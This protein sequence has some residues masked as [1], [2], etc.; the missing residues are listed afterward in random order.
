MTPPATPTTA[1]KGIFHRDGDTTLGPPDAPRALA[2]LDPALAPI[3]HAQG[4]PRVD[5]TATLFQALVETIC[6][7]QLSMQAATTVHKRLH[8]A[9]G[10]I[11]PTRVLE[12]S[13]QELAN[14]GL[15]QAKAQY[16]T[17]IAH[18]LSQGKLEASTLRKA[19]DEAVQKHLARLPGI[20]P[21]SAKIIM[22]FHL[23]REDVFP[24]SDAGL[25]D[26]A[27]RLLGFEE[28]P[29]ADMLAEHASTWAPYRSLAA[30]YLWGARDQVLRKIGQR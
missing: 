24:A 10:E 29:P 15:S 11:F 2:R 23:H 4:P 7:Q 8:D 18:A 30:W 22:I 3:I 12:A 19:D 21:W 16:V 27:E 26:A 1:K 5:D 14:A 28:P 17:T 20:G 25:I 9:L 13:T 6:H